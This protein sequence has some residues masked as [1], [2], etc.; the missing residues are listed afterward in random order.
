VTARDD[1]ADVL[2]AYRLT[3]LVVADTITEP[4]R[5]RVV[6][7]AYRRADRGDENAWT[8]L[9]GGRVETSWLDHASADEDPPKL[10]TLVTCPYCAG[11]WVAAGVVLA[12]RWRW[13]PPVRDAL[14]L[15]AAAAL[16]RAAEPE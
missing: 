8:N 5:E 16:V 10:A 12:R 6:G 14:A 11:V 13:W 7:W 3:R 15:A 1:A 9:L 4:L 2:A